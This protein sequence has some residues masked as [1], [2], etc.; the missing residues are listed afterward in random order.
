MMQLIAVSSEADQ[1]RFIDLPVSLYKKNKYWIRPLD[2]DVKAVFDPDLN[3][4]FNYGACQ[5]WLLEDGGRVVGRIAAF[6]KKDPHGAEVAE[7]VSGGVGF[8]ECIDDQQAANLLFDAAREWISDKGAT[9]M[10]GPI[11]F[12][13][14]DKWWG[15]L[16][17]GFDQEPNYQCNYN[18][19][20]YK[21]LFETYGFKTY[22][23]QYTFLKPV[24]EPLSPR[25]EEKAKKVARNPDYTFD[26]LR[27]SNFD[28]YASDIIQVYNKAWVKHEGVNEISLEQG[29]AIMEQLKPVLDEEIIWIAY[30][31]ED[32]VA[33]FVCI[34]E[35]NQI[36]KHLNGRLDLLG[37]LKFLWYKRIRNKKKLLGM[38]FGVVPAHQGKGVDGAIIHVM[39]NVLLPKRKYEMLEMSGIG[40]FNPKMILV[41]RQVGGTVNKVHTTYRYLFD[42]SQPFERMKSIR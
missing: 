5:R 3:K 25:L 31:K 21:D 7:E 15:L 28:K 32:P 12:G 42:R 1:K 41:V 39:A 8:F 13:R 24:H 33:I 10:D 18:F 14:R 40:D 38:I 34:P 6:V 19:P 36:V 22:Y 9:Y 16:T 11:N 20:Y 17:K 27:L 37:K 29:R 35:V 23:E 30:Y 26:H 2:K 4:T